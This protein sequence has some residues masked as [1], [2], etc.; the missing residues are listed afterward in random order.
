MTRTR[1]LGGTDAGSREYRLSPG[2]N[3][4]VGVLLL[5]PPLCKMGLQ[6]ASICAILF[7]GSRSELSFTLPKP[8]QVV[9]N[10][11]RL[12]PTLPGPSGG[13]GLP[14]R[15]VHSP[16]RWGNIRQITDLYRWL[17]PS[18][19][20]KIKARNSCSQEFSMKRSGYFRTETLYQTPVA[21][22]RASST[23]W[24]SFAACL[25]QLL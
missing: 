10:H 18:R 12:N 14:P 8:L 16:K 19:E 5:T 23:P 15:V 1:N 6:I 4:L 2:K 20:C 24:A 11:R 21:D 7:R 9:H 25:G 3:S 13:S 17:A 22:A